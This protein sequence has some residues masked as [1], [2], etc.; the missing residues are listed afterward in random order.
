[1]ALAV[2]ALLL[3]SIVRHSL[4]SNRALLAK[5]TNFCLN[6][7]SKGSNLKNKGTRKV[8]VSQVRIRLTKE[9]IKATASHH[10]SGIFP[11]SQ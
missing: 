2:V 9:I 4:I 11:I 1:M 8:G 6:P 5:P 10:N 7:S 3:K